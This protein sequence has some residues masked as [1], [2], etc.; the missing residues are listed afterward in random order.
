MTETMGGAY[1]HLPYFISVALADVL[2]VRVIPPLAFA[3]LAYPLMGLN[4]FA[5]GKWTLF[6][7]AAILVR[8]GQGGGGG[9]ELHKKPHL[10]LSQEFEGMRNGGGGVYTG[11]G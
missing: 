1:G 7:F 2:L 5:D 8:V 3:V 9:E 6:W 11:L 4:E 10:V